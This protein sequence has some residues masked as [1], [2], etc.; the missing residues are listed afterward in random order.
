MVQNKKK[1]S[2][3]FVVLGAVLC[4][5]A[6]Y[7]LNGA[8]EPGMEM[9]AFL[10][11]FNRV[12]AEP[13]ANYYN[14][15]TMKAV[16]IAL[17][18][19]ATALLM[20]ITSQRNFMPGKEFGTARFESP[21]MAN[22]I[23]ADKDVNFNRI[24]SQNVK[25]SLN[26]R[27]LKLN[28]NILICGGSGA[29]KTFYEVKPNLMQM[30]HNCSFICTDPKREILRSCGEMLRN[31]GYSV[32]VINLLE[33][34]K[35]DCYNPFSY[36][37]EETDVV[38]LITNLISN[39]T[40]KGAT[41]S[42]PFWEKAEGLFLQAIFYYVWLEE[43]PARRNFETV[44]QLLGEA[45]VT[46]QN[47]PSRLDVRM[48]FLEETSKL[49][50]AHP[51][52]KQYNK[53][54]RGA[55]DTVRSIIIS[56]NSRL[57]FLENK[58]VLRLL[59]RD[60]LD[61]AELGIGVNGDG[62][63]KTALFCVIPDSDKSY[64]FI[65]G[66]LYTQI[67]Q[68]LYYQADFNCGGRLPIHVTFMLDEFANVALPDDY[69]SLLSTMRSRE[70]SS[71]II[72]QNFAQLK[73]LFKDTW[74]TI[75]GNCDTFIYL[76]GNE[77]STHKYVSE[78]L[79]KGTID[80]KSSGETK[81]RQ[82][83]SSRNYDVLGRELFTADE[84]RKLDNKKCI[85]FIRGFDPIM[86]SKFIPFG[87]PAFD[88]T[89]DGKGKPYVHVPNSGGG[90]QAL[91]F[92]LLTPKALSYYEELKKKGENVYIDKIDYKDFELLTD[93]GMQKRFISMEEQEQKEQLNREQDNELMYAQEDV[94]EPEAAETKPKQAE[95]EPV[96]EPEAAGR[97]IE[98]EDT[99]MN[100]MAQWKY[101]KE[102]KDELHKMIALGMPT[103]TILAVFYPE[104]DVIKMREIRKT[105]Q[106]VRHSEN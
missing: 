104:T 69:C 34:E 92:Q 74:E 15:T 39:T 14:Q 60:D 33:M 62:E 82:G 26:F 54:M 25:M 94:P 32:K 41:P 70:I 43:P 5:Y 29:G 1:V 105:F 16:V 28:G 93:A 57:A 67:F 102:Q 61:L 8:W 87:H 77:Q 58:Q 75:P 13:F 35:S 2:L 45:E 20:Y 56:A 86:D 98:G 66:M 48:K 21:Q 12:C 64:N 11:S 10:E 63:T 18:V 6:G 100:R 80:K 90:G 97:R 9:N 23:L 65:I 42:D 84:V 17:I 51:A 79:G 78:L 71:I 27:R 76:G 106:T 37:R 4:A 7:L 68:E 73:A 44:L 22:K 59:S 46:E 52:V 49:G 47:K 85:I 19:Y 72:I 36:I 96:P 101:S 3:W 40:P 95:K 83:S 30:P 24:L 99:I 89:A 55:G 31:N 38:K 50:S 81:G 53:C 103:K 88:Q 91:P